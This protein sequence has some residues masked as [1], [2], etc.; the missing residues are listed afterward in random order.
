MA[1]LPGS[2]PVQ[3]RKEKVFQLYFS[4]AHCQPPA[5]SPPPTSGS[6]GRRSSSPCHSHDPRCCHGHRHL[7]LP[8][9]NLGSCLL[10]PA[11]ASGCLLLGS[12]RPLGSTVRLSDPAQGRQT[13]LRTS[14]LPWRT[15]S[16]KSRYGPEPP[17]LARLLLPAASDPP[18]SARLRSLPD[19]LSVT[20]HPPHRATWLSGRSAAPCR[21]PPHPTD[22]K[23]PVA[24]PPPEALQS[25]GSLWFSLL[26]ACFSTCK[27]GRKEVGPPGRGQSPHC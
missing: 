21:L 7:C 13:G 8:G 20:S 17:P 27:G 10:F 1:C 4:R 5:R 9:L 16:R 11:Q 6:E 14:V 22:G 23:Q 18:L 2:G 25:P 26:P 19:S 3:R 15:G 12:A 24:S